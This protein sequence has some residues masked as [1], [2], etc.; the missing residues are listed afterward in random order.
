MRTVINSETG[1]VNSPGRG[2]YSHA[3]KPSEGENSKGFNYHGD[4]FKGLV[5]SQQGFRRMSYLASIGRGST[6]Q[7]SKT[8]KERAEKRSERQFR[9]YL[10]SMMLDNI[11]KELLL[12]GAELIYVGLEQVRNS[13]WLHQLETMHSI[14]AEIDS[15][16][17]NIDKIDTHIEAFF[18]ED[19]LAQE[20]L[21]EAATE[22]ARQAGDHELNKICSELK[23]SYIQFK[24]GLY[25]LE[26][27]G[28]R[29]KDG[30]FL[31]KQE[32]GSYA[33]LSDRM[34]S[35]L[36][37]EYSSIIEM[38]ASFYSY[39]QSI[40]EYIETLRVSGAIE[41]V[42][43][44]IYSTSYQNIIEN[45]ERFKN[46]F[47]KRAEL[48]NSLD[49]HKEQVTT[50]ESKLKNDSAFQKFLNDR[51]LDTELF[52][53]D[54]VLKA[55]KEQSIE[56][57]QTEKELLQKR[58]SLLAQYS[59][60]HEL[61]EK[62]QAQLIETESIITEEFAQKSKSEDALKDLFRLGEFSI[63]AQG[64]KKDFE[65]ERA[66]FHDQLSDTLTDLDELETR[67][68]EISFLE[69]ASKAA[70][71]NVCYLDDSY[72]VDIS[73][74]VR[75]TDGKAI[76]SFQG[77]EDGKTYYVSIDENDNISK[78]SE[79]EIDSMHASLANNPQ[80][81][82]F[83]IQIYTVASRGS[84]KVD[85]SEI[86]DDIAEKILASPWLDKIN[87]AEQK[88]YSVWNEKSQALN[89]ELDGIN[90]EISKRTRTSEPKS[91]SDFFNNAQA[92]ALIKNAVRIA[93]AAPTTAEH[94]EL[95]LT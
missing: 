40:E 29:Y 53:T 51:G 68:D 4:D 6:I 55:V 31:Q 7:G 77:Y 42:Y 26:E 22:A 85:I 83:D 10:E 82:L 24:E 64:Q 9:R 75:T 46:L 11:N 23:A 73:T 49:I 14:R 37:S 50:L 32:D 61:V 19:R 21:L 63:A 30:V 48:Q 94:P 90:H 18:G 27:Q 58:E 89:K 34:Q 65:A 76:V 12:V 71:G 60:S 3:A 84:C 28:L 59:I 47:E 2:G 15:L 93:N 41:A 17:K 88:N 52:H 5:V 70:A 91:T 92:N 66:D 62:A 8:E 44:Q 56:L 67:Y 57:S 69:Q 39:A 54:E 86:D 33:K 95:T 38:E 36:T 78:L 43:A 16:Q 25:E 20:E 81:N 79:D 87:I 1:N 80:L 13:R 35:Q 74:A 72:D 45:K